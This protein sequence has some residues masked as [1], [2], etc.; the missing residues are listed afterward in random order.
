[1]T[2]Y[3]IK[4]ESPIGIHSD[5]ELLE[6]LGE[7]RKD[8]F[9]EIYLRYWREI[10]LVAYRKVRHKAL[11]EE[12]AQNLFISLW[13]R[14]S[15]MDIRD[16]RSYLFSSLKYSI[17]NH[18]KSQIVHEKYLTYLQSSRDEVTYSTEQSILMGDLSEA[19]EKGVSLLPKKTQ[20]VFMLSRVENR[21]VKDIARALKIS[22]K[23]VEYHVTQSLKAMRIYLKDYLVFIF[24]LIVV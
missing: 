11:A 20:L 10:F 3:F 17:I 4:V 24:F 16:L 12:L 22:E 23:A 1:M 19:I 5:K 7:G 21:S 9:K 8:A 15:E 13:E 14:R 6:G 18:Y 2:L